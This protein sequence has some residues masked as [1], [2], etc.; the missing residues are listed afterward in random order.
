MKLVTGV[1]YN[2]GGTCIYYMS[3][4][5]TTSTGTMTINDVSSAEATINPYPIYSAAITDTV[6]EC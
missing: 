3:I 2:Y 5:S 1:T 6:E 4:A